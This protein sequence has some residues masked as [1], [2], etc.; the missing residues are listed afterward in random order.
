MR[1]VVDQCNY[2]PSNITDSSDTNMALSRC[3]YYNGSLKKLCCLHINVILQQ[4]PIPLPACRKFKHFH[5]SYICKLFS[6][7]N[8]VKR[9][10]ILVAL[11]T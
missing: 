8:N 5:I 11:R 3:K 7:G 4:I 9:V 6:S 10:V 1:V 2:I